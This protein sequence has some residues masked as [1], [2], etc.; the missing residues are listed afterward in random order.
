MEENH[1][2][3]LVKPGSGANEKDQGQNQNKKDD[4]DPMEELRKRKNEDEK[5]DKKISKRGPRSGDFDDAKSLSKEKKKRA[6]PIPLGTLTRGD[7]PSVKTEQ[8][9]SYFTE[10]KPKKE[11]DD[12]NGNSHVYRKDS[13][14]FNDGA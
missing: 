2:G 6:D 3:T 7:K 13:R 4:L 9:S 14:N 11:R 5:F 1:Y 10:S 12:F 8:P